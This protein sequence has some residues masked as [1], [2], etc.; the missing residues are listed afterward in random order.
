MAITE[1]VTDNLVT[2]TNRIETTYPGGYYSSGGNFIGPFDMLT[3]DNWIVHTRNPKP[4]F[5]EC[6]HEVNDIHHVPG[7]CGWSKPPQFV[8][9]FGLVYSQDEWLDAKAEFADIDIDWSAAMVNI[10]DNVQGVL[11]RTESLAV[12]IAELASLK[13][14]VPGIFEGIVRWP[15]RHWKMN[16]RDMASSH[17]SVEFGL[18][19]LIR[20]LTEFKNLKDK[21][22]EK[23][24]W[25][26]DNVYKKTRVF[27]RSVVE[28]E[29][30]YSAPVCANR[31]KNFE[32]YN[33]EGFDKHKVVGTLGAIVSMEP[34]NMATQLT[35][36]W[37]NG[38]GLNN[39]VGIAWELIPFSF[40]VDW[41]VPV[42]K[43]L[44]ANDPFPRD[45]SG[46]AKAYHFHEFWSSIKRESE[47]TR[48]C[49]VRPKLG[50]Y[51]TGSTVTSGTIEWTRKRRFYLRTRGLPAI[52]AL[53]PLPNQWSWNRSALSLSLLV[54]KAK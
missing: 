42:G 37:I 38:L 11:P 17:L 13:K 27:G 20:D 29:D 6:E 53:P 51:P 48:I 33:N 50:T 14:L 12:N 8:S 34:H 35:R 25:F 52:N 31:D 47:M 49:D 43:W 16:I 18:M 9:R 7:T 28:I 30:P 39:P 21:I 40:V 45:I 10:M 41:F 2:K 54:Q 24:D 4:A 15:R 22:K 46:L 3:D 26:N 23:M 1:V 19:P 44:T 5:N 36:S 32:N